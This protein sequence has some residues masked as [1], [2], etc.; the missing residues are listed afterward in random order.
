[1]IFL[2]KFVW[3]NR[4]RALFHICSKSN[5][6]LGSFEHTH[7]ITSADDLRPGRSLE[8]IVDLLES[9]SLISWDTEPE[10]PG[11]TSGCAL[12]S[13]LPCSLH[14]PL[15]TNFNLCQ[16]TALP[17]QEDSMVGFVLDCYMAVFAS[18]PQLSHANPVHISLTLTFY[19]SFLPQSFQF[20]SFLV[21]KF[22][23]LCPCK[24]LLDINW[25]CVILLTSL[26]FLS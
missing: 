18:Y 25:I 21:T 9:G 8:L 24:E 6:T 5:K 4:N 20:C 2:Y 16:D 22:P 11:T 17:C 7:S 10:T 3:S 23:S 13:V 12:V 19:Q 1:M 15:F 14:Q 26:Q